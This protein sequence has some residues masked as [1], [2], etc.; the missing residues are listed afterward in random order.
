MT[1]SLSESRIRPNPGSDQLLE[2]LEQQGNSTVGIGEII[3][4]ALDSLLANKVRS[5]LTMLGVIIGVG[6]VI[7]LMALGDGA[8]SAI[9]GEFEAI[10]TNVLTIS[11]GS[12]SNQGPGQSGGQ[13]QTLTMDDAEAIATLNLPVIAV[14]PQLN[15]STRLVA[16]AADASATVAGVTAA[17]DTINEPPLRSGTF[18]DEEQVQNAESVIVLGANVA[19]ELFGSGEALG[20]TVRVEGQPL[21]VT[22][23]LEA[24][25]GG[26]F[27]SVDDQAFVPITL[28]QQRLFGTRTPDGNS[29]LVSS[30]AVSAYNSDDL[31]EIEARIATLLRD[32]HRLAADGSEDD[33]N[34]LNQAE[35]LDTLSIVTGLLTTFL[36]AVAGI[37]LV[38]GGI[39]IMNIMLVSVTER[40][41]EIG[42]RKAVGARGGDISLQFVV[43][44]L[45]LSVAGGLIGVVLG[46]VISLAVTLSGLLEASISFGAVALALGFSLAVGLFF[47]IYPA[48]RAAQ[49]NP[50]EALRHE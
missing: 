31:S 39:G 3:R 48:Q 30:I 28:A 21:R 35:I 7:S 22:G 10:G 49:L 46:G 50:I 32:R 24:Q 6:A 23:V 33:F 17:Y 5:L 26:A 27:G 16:A 47:G 41:R 13:A 2:P 44:A 20:Q 43:E 4:I 45:V 1:I 11:P 9:T 37:S 8:T 34:V 29:Y 15:N 18:I 42:L 14:S 38:V 40:T 36:A 19:T 12:S 25:G